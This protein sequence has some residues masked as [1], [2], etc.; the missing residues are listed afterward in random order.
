MAWTSADLDAVEK[1]L[2][3]G[4]LVVQHS[5]G[6]RITYRSIAELTKARSI[7]KNELNPPTVAR[8]RRIL[9][10]PGWP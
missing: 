2:A 1:A 10:R 6:R 4:E 9:S 5:D 8:Q 7:I 3:S